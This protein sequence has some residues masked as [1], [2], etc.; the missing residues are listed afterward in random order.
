MGGRSSK[1]GKAP[2][3]LNSNGHLPQNGRHRYNSNDQRIRAGGDSG[4]G[5]LDHGSKSKQNELGGKPQRSEE[6]QKQS[7]PYS[8][9]ANNSTDEFYD[10]IPLYS[11]SRSK[12]TGSRQGAVSKV[13]EVSSRLGRVGSVGLGKAVEV[14]DTLG[15]SMTNLNPKGGF[16]FAA[17]TKG[18]ELEILAFEVAN[19]IVKGFNLMQSLSKRNIKRLKELLPSEG[20][21]NLVS[22]NT[23]EL[24][25]IFAADKR[26]ELKVFSCEVFRFGNRCKDPQ[27]HNL[28]RYFEKISKEFAPQRQLQDEAESVMEVL[29]IL[30]QNT[31]ELYQELQLLDKLDQEYQ[32][33]LS[34]DD[35]PGKGQKGDGTAILRAELKSQKKEVRNLKKKSL[36]SRSL[37]EVTGKLVDVVRFLLMEIDD[38]FGREDSS[39]LVE[40]SASCHQRLGPVGLS[41][42]YANV[43]LQIDD[44]ISIIGIKD[45][46]EK[47]LAWLVPM[48]TNTAKDHHGFGWVGEW[49]N[50]ASEGSRRSVSGNN[51]FIRIES[52][53]HADKE[54]TETYILEL[55]LWLHHLVSKSKKASSARVDASKSPPLPPLQEKPDAAESGSPLQITIEEQRTTESTGEEEGKDDG[56]S[57][58]TSKS[59]DFTITLLTTKT[60]LENNVG[61]DVQSEPL[62]LCVF[63]C[64]YKITFWT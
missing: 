7:F 16:A 3:V 56:G 11:S 5:E 57:L 62:S 36:W 42:H 22:V 9:P 58:E 31:A 60:K 27:W 64:T 46:M 19:T 1:N 61:G 30:V 37:E 23:D 21:Q 40:S 48:S 32:R 20:V 15:S 29:M 52:L 34:E 53:H 8:S 38:T 18:N 28:D 41:L 14:L 25:R 51:D 35:K 49:A 13:S 43:V 33:K 4:A 12:S 63:I 10:G 2:R 50:S 44:I 59:E 45:E 39:A 6:L 26:D 55:L 24:L 54:K 47:T 17:T